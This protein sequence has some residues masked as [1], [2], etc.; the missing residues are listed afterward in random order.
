M[1]NPVDEVVF[2]L[3]SERNELLDMFLHAATEFSRRHAEIA[4]SPHQ[5]VRLE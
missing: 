5:A 4:A 3:A 1:A 2:A